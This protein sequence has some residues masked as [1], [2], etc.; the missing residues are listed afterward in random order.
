MSYL[1]M[2]KTS[3]WC[4]AGNKGMTYKHF[5]W[6]RGTLGSFPH[7]LLST[8]KKWNISGGFVFKGR[9]CFTGLDPYSTRIHVLEAE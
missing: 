9:L 7:S 1:Q 8:S 2:V 5:V 6:L 3:C 4:E